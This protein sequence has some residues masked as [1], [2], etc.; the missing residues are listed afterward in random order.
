MTRASWAATAL[1]K[2]ERDSRLA[3]SGRAEHRDEV[4][5]ALVHDPLP[6]TGEHCELAI[7]PDHRHLGGGALPDRCRG[8]NGQPRLDRSLLPLRNDGLRRTVLDRAAGS[9]VRLL[10]DEHGPDRGRG[11]QPR[12][13]VDDVSRDE[14]LTA[15]GARIECDDRLARVDGDTELEPF[16]LR[17]VAD[18]ERSADGALGIVAVR[19]RRTEDSHDRVPDE[20]LD[21]AAVTFELAADAFVVRNEECSHVFGVELLGTR[22]EPHEIHEEDRHEAP[23]LATAREGVERRAACVAELRIVRVLLTTARTGEHDAED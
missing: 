6:N 11:L 22:G 3:D 23:F 21:A 2:L 15:L 18:G 5:P 17:P 9:D 16:A 7:S 12:G 1:C 10:S 14:R 19:H 13:S 8:V 4:A 20:L